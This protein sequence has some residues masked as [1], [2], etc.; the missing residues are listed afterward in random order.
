MLTGENSIL[1]Q[2][3]T[4]KEKTK[5]EEAKEEL[6]IVLQEALIEKN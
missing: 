6:A 1:N 3:T 5:M 2:A 4:A